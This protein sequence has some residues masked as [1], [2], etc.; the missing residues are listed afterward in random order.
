MKKKLFIIVLGVLAL[1]SCLKNQA[2]VFDEPSSARMENFLENVRVALQGP[3]QGWALS[4]YPG[5]SYATCYMAL[6][7][8][9]QQVEARGQSNPD[10]AYTSNYKLTKDNGA[11]LSFDTYNEVIHY[12]ATP[13][14]THYQAR[15]GDF[16]FDIIKV[17]GDTPGLQRIVLRGKRS[18]NYCYL[19]PLTT[20][21]ASFLAQMNRAEADLTIV[22]FEGTV[23]GGAVEGFLDPGTHTFSIGRKGAESSEIVSARYMVVPGG[24]LFNEPFTFQGIEFSQFAYDGKTGILSAYVTYEGEAF[25]IAFDKVIPDGYVSYEEFLGEWQFYCYDGQIEFPIELVQK[26]KGRSYSMKG[27]SPYFEPEIGYNGAR[28]Y[29]TWLNQAVGTNGSLT[30]VLAGWEYPA[31]TSLWPYV[32]ETGMDGK[33]VDNSVAELE[34]K[35]VDNGNNEDVH[36]HGWVLWQ[37]DAAGNSAGDFSGWDDAG[38]ATGS[39]QIPGNITMTKIVK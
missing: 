26:E 37:L 28:G 23:M 12:Y 18:R 2:D 36:P 6:K 38:T 15:G 33:A 35:W 10:V 32:D 3:A 9:D 11:V 7:F 1:S 34:V 22:A 8:T 5:S 21:A 17:E 27:L 24:I 30:I 31:S 29:L 4:Y 39:N 14:D 16:E 25:N 19:N 13:D 20:D